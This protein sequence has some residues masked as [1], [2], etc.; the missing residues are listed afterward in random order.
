MTIMTDAFG[1]SKF[2][3]TLDAGIGLNFRGTRNYSKDFKRG[4]PY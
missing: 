3:D 4:L 1:V 2:Q